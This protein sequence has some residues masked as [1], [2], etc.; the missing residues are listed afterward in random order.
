MKFTL[1]PFSATESVPNVEILGKIDR[2]SHQLQLCYQLF[3][4]LPEIIIPTP[5]DIPN[6]QDELWRETCFEFF[7]GI[8]KSSQYWEFNLSPAGHWNVYHFEAY[9]QGMQ[10]ESAVTELPFRVEQ[11]THGLT[12]TLATDLERLGLA[13]RSL[14][15]AITSVIKKIDK[16]VTYWA[17]THRGSQADFHLRE[18]FILEL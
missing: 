2:S 10:I 5:A 7:L 16:T 3:G 17:L 4:N 9:R 1:Q 12:V 15:V 13:D 6:R 8:P 18:S 11:Q 14:D